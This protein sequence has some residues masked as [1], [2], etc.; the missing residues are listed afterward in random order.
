VRPGVELGLPGLFLGRDLRAALGAIRR[1][2]ERAALEPFEQRGR[3]GARVAVDADRNRLDEAEHAR[4][5]IDLNDLGLLRPVV[6]PMLRQVPKGPSRVPSA[7]TT[8]AC[9]ISF[10]AAFEP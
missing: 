2:R 5:G 4:V 8:S 3:G 1:G 6:E 9:A 7:K 10:M